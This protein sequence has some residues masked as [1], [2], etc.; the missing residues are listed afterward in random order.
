M[1]FTLQ[2]ALS[3]LN[4]HTKEFNSKG[5]GNLNTKADEVIIKDFKGWKKR[6]E[7]KEMISFRL[8]RLK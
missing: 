8:S 2:M 4:D 3:K 6:S 7:T 5:R 1:V